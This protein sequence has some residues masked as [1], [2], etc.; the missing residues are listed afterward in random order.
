MAFII[1][2]KIMAYLTLLTSNKNLVSREEFRVTVTRNR[3]G[4]L[5]QKKFRQLCG[6]TVKVEKRFQALGQFFAG[7][8]FHLKSSKKY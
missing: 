8:R 4:R 3:S 7:N 6:N 5:F 2:Q 1:F